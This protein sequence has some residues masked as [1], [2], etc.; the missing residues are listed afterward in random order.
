MKELGRFSIGSGDR[1]GREG[2]AQLAAVKAV[3]DAGTAVDVVW[4]KSN[5][6]HTL[7]GTSPADQRRVADAAAAAAGWKTPYFVDADHIGLK[8][9]DKFVDHCDFFTIDVADFIGEEAPAADIEAFVTARKDLIGERKVDGLKTPLRIDEALLRSVA[10]RYL[11]AVKEAGAVYRQVLARKGAGN[12][13]VEVSMDETADPQLPGELFL[14][15]AALAAEGVPANTIAPKFSGRFNKGVDYVGAVEDFLSEFEADVCVVAEAVR[16]FGL[17]KNLKLSV[18][19]GSDKFSLYPGIRR[20]VQERNAGLHL[21]TCGTTWLEE[22]IGLAEGGGEGLTIACDIYEKSLARYDELIAPYATVVDID[23]PK[24]PAI[25]AVR[26]WS[27]ERFAA[28]LRH[29]QKEPRFDPNFRQLLHVAF[30]IAG[31]MGARYLDAL[32]S[33]RVHVERNVTENLL[34]RHLRP[35]FLG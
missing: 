34:E 3:I 1:F 23:R 30:R 2:G 31:E 6:E 18:H 27:G 17:P 29:D 13:V 28:A 11:V 12:F 24:L 26:A 15:L 19:S 4:N 10:K 25:A 9:V 5:R 22:L 35:L 32:E 7:L 16:A 33:H 21:K 14:I 8:T 20:I